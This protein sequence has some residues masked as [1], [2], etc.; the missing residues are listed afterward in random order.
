MRGH[1]VLVYLDDFDEPDIWG[2]YCLDC[3]VN[4]FGYASD[5]R[6]GRLAKAHEKATKPVLQEAG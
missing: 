1:T 6:P 2:Y 3:P 4:G 5:I